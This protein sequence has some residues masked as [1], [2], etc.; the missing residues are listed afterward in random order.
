VLDQVTRIGQLESRGN[1]F[2]AALQETEPLTEL[3]TDHSER[4]F[5]CGARGGAFQAVILGIRSWRVVP[6]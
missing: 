3:S 5:S 6:Y 4:P 2:A 1:G